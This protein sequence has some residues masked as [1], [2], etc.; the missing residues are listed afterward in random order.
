MFCIQSCCTFY[1]VCSM[2]PRSLTMSLT[3][4]Q[5]QASIEI[6]GEESF[7]ATLPKDS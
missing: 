2:D 4:L 1:V 6:P 5:H 7:T 3:V